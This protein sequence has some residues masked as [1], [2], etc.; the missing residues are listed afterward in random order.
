MRYPT[1]SIHSYQ[2]VGVTLGVTVLYGIQFSANNGR[3]MV[4]M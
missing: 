2:G 4:L 3:E 1:A